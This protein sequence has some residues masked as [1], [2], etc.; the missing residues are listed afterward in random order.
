MHVPG[1]LRERQLQWCRGCWRGTTK[2]WRQTFWW[3]QDSA[4]TGT[5]LC[6]ALHS[7]S[8]SL[9]HYS[10]SS[11]CCRITVASQVDL[12]AFPF[13]RPSISLF[14]FIK[15]KKS[16]LIRPWSPCL[17]PEGGTTHAREA[18]LELKASSDDAR[19][20]WKWASQEKPCLGTISR[21]TPQSAW[22]WPAG[23]ILP[24]WSVFKN[25]TQYFL[26]DYN[27]WLPRRN[28]LEI[29]GCFISHVGRSWGTQTHIA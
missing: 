2:E 1:L 20:T 26:K 24:L 28:Y 5:A 6:K 29:R 10:V 11:A 17:L 19:V 15:V 25:I 18:D 16:L 8:R 27:D 21:F 14:S 4:A 7:T 22:Q 9:V 3:Q 13:A 12:L 23:L